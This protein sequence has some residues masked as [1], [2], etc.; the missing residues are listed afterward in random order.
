MAARLPQAPFSEDLKALHRSLTDVINFLRQTFDNGSKHVSFTQ[1]QIDQ[2]TDR[3][4][5]G[6]IVFNSTTNESNVS[7]QDM[8]GDIK[9][10]AF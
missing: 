9:W 5:L 2:M 8:N 4:A 6:T 3:T 1:D 7:Y 10:R